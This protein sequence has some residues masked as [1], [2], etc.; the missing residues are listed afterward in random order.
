MPAV[1]APPPPLPP[2]P[3]PS[4][5]VAATAGSNYAAQIQAARGVGST[6]LTSGQGLTGAANGSFPT[7]TLLGS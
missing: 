3:N 6:I 1:P 7:K 5:A 2:P 4:T